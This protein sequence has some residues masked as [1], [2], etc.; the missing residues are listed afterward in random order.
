MD[1]TQLQHQQSHHTNWAHKWRTKARDTYLLVKKMLLVKTDTNIPITIANQFQSQA[2]T[3]LYHLHHSAPVYASGD[4]HYA[5]HNLYNAKVHPDIHRASRDIP[6]R[7]EED[8]A[9]ADGAATKSHHL[10]AQKRPGS[11]AADLQLNVHPP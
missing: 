8:G 10:P 2:N 5:A 3:S 7:E 4:V 1:V 9:A 6:A 11:C